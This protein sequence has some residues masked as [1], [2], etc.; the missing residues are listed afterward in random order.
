MIESEAREQQP[1]CR[2]ETRAGSPDLPSDVSA[3]GPVH[4][5]TVCDRQLESHIVTDASSIHGLRWAR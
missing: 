2:A 3:T 4:L 1:V 5:E